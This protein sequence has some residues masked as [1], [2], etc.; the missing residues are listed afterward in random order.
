MVDFY[1]ILSFIALWKFLVG[2]IKR[3]FK[4]NI[5]VLLEK[6]LNWLSPF[7]SLI[8]EIG[9]VALSPTRHFPFRSLSKFSRANFLVA[10]LAFWLF[11]FEIEVPC[12][13]LP[14]H[15]GCHQNIA[16][17]IVVHYNSNCFRKGDRDNLGLNF[18][19]YI[20]ASS[21]S[22]SFLY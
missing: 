12:G 18:F 21:S 8:A 6:L 15:P 13:S 11:S 19:L 1:N 17:T 14:P 16:T 7:A 10:A 2:I 3:R 5:S 4:V 20:M 22:N 9:I